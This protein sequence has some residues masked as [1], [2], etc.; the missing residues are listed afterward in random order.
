LVVIDGAVG[1]ERFAVAFRRDGECTGVLAV[2]RPRIAV[3]SRMRMSES[4]D[5]SHVVPS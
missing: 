1:E 4:R 5:W 2:N 3:M